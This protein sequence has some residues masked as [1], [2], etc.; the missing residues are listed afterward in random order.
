MRYYNSICK[1]FVNKSEKNENEETWIIMGMDEI[2]M[3]KATSWRS[4]L[5][6]SAA[7]IHL[8]LSQNTLFSLPLITFK[9][10]EG[11]VLLALNDK[12]EDEKRMERS[13]PEVVED[14]KVIPLPFPFL[15]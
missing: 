14:V 9:V 12:K 13:V 3:K 6:R 2:I 4:L 10:K 11:R 8:L 1:V 7:R 15:F 5:N